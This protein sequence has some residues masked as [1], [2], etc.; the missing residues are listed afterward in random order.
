MLGR[1]VLSRLHCLTRQQTNTLTLYVDLDQGSQAN[2][3][4]GFRVQGE[5]LLRRLRSETG[6]D[7][8]LE[9]A[10][11]RAGELLNSLVPTG[12]SVVIVV[13]PESR[14]EEVHQV[15]IR[16]PPSATWRRGAFLRPIVEAMDDNE[17]YAVVLADSRTARLFLVVLGEIREFDHLLSETESRSRA[18][19]T[20]Q[21]RAESRHRRRHEESVAHH[22]KRIIDALRDLAL[23]APYDR[24]II[25]GAPRTTALIEKLLPRRLHGKLVSTVPMAVTAP[26]REVLE[27]TMDIQR[28]MERDQERRIVEGLLSELHEGGRAVSGLDDVCDA[29]TEARVWTLVYDSSLDAEGGE[30]LECGLMT[31]KTTGFCPRC[32][33]G[34]Q[35]IEFLVDRLAQVVL[36]TG[37]R[38][39][40]VSD[41]A[42]EDLRAVGS[43]GALLRY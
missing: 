32:Q 35:P 33:A 23:E 24:L 22:A 43:I 17:R 11:E 6:P 26:D 5:A 36:D 3:R 10:A 28:R 12:R 41:A 34:L 18:V 19:G 42:A 21:R 30:C 31:T 4:G 2:R 39:E 9:T 27:R 14:L 29:V 25:A 7:P 15:D 8:Q 1:G 37:G 16:F 38:V 20:D 40:V 13:H